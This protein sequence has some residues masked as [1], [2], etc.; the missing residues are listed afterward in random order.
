MIAARKIRMLR[1]RL[2]YFT[3]LDVGAVLA[4][5]VADAKRLV[6][7]GSAVYV[8]GRAKPIQV[9]RPHDASRNESDEGGN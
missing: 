3:R 7:D 1:P 5:R 2:L 9:E 4:A 6:E 8:T